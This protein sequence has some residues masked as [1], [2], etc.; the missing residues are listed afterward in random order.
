MCVLSPMCAGQGSLLGFRDKV[1]R[2]P[3]R[4]VGDRV[5]LTVEV[6]GVSEVLCL[7]MDCVTSTACGHS[8][9]SWKSVMKELGASVPGVHVPSPPCVLTWLFLCVFAS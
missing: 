1:A 4:S 3:R 5:C 2:L 9:G 7:S 6:A 8:P